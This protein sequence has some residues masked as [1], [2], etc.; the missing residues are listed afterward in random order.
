MDSIIHQHMYIANKVNSHS[1]MITVERLCDLYIQ[2][3]FQLNHEPEWTDKQKSALIECI[4]LGVPMMSIITIN[5][6]QKGEVV[7]GSRILKT[8]IE[9][10]ANCFELVN[11]TTLTK[12][13][14]CMYDDLPEYLQTVFDNFKLMFI[15]IC[16]NPKDI[17]D[18][19]KNTVRNCFDHNEYIA[20][21]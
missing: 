14:G 15:N 20:I 4:L 2:R 1:Y 6:K 18:N 13:N 10:K 5:N 21:V 11:T 7:S 17:P 3:C 9:F 12:L 19:I 8:I 16:G